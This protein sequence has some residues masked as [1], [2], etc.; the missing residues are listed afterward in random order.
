MT[1][2][3]ETAAIAILKKTIENFDQFN[4]C[5]YHEAL[6]ENKEKISYMASEAKSLCLVGGLKRAD[7]DIIIIR[8][9]TPIERGLGYKIILQTIKQL[10]MEKTDSQKEIPPEWNE[11]FLA[12]FNDSKN[13]TFPVIK[14][15]IEE[16]LDKLTQGKE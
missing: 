8:N 15:L 4:W 11:Q 2:R 16:A 3:E 5:Q 9:F 12:E 10:I 6:N 7:W 1:T 13:Q 14:E